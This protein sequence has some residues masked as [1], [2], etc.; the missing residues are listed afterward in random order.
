MLLLLQGLVQSILA[1]A[2]SMETSLRRQIHLALYRIGISTRHYYDHSQPH[3]DHGYAM[4][5][6][7]QRADRAAAA[8]ML[9]SFHAQVNANGNDAMH[10][11]LMHCYQASS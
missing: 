7:E 5:L 1:H 8:L 10:A 6:R 9:S 2:S 3:L 4:S 11:G